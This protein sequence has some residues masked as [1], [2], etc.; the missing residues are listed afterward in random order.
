VDGRRQESEYLPSAVMNSRDDDYSKKGYQPLAVDADQ[1]A[2]M[3]LTLDDIFP[4][5]VTYDELQ[6]RILD[7]SDTLGLEIRMHK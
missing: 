2:A 7:A 4:P 6:A 3:V 5:A 1:A